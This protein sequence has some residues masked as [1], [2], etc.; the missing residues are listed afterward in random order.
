MSQP[1]QPR[2]SA[3]HSAAPRVEAPLVEALGV[4]KTFSNGTVALAGRLR[5]LPRTKSASINVSAGEAWLDRSSIGMALSLKDRPLWQR[6][7]T[8]R[9]Q[10]C[11]DV[12]GALR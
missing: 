10:G 4:G 7:A 11:F 8:G 5:G 1:E 6:S 12:S 9:A 3:A 2:D